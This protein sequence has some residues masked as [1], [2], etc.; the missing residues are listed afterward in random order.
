MFCLF[1]TADPVNDLAG[2]KRSDLAKFASFFR[3]CLDRGIYF[4][5]SQ[6]ETGFISIAHQ[7]SD[8]DATARV[9]REA[10]AADQGAAV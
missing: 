8:L 4:A 3:N 5:P 9:M 6:F 1:F 2:A 10:L 7:P